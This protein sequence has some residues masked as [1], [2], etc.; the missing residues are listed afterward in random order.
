MSDASKIDEVVNERMAKLRRMKISPFQLIEGDPLFTF[1]LELWSTD[2]NI[3]HAS[4]MTKLIRDGIIN[5]EALFKKLLIGDTTELLKDYAKEIHHICADTI[6]RHNFSSYEQAREF[7]ENLQME[8]KAK[9]IVEVYRR[10]MLPL[11]ESSGLKAMFLQAMSAA[12]AP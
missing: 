7:V 9:L 4:M 2:Q 10:N 1:Q 8:L 5:R 11:V 12:K 3:S 6:W